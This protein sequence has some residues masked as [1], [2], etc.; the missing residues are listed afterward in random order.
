[1][2][3]VETAPVE[4]PAP[5]ANPRPPEGKIPGLDITWGQADDADWTDEFIG[6]LQSAKAQYKDIHVVPCASRWYV[7]RPL[8]RREYRNLVQTQ[9]ETMTQQ[10]ENAASEGLSPEGV[11][12][13]L[14]MMNEE[15]ISVQATIYPAF[16]KDTI[17]NESA[18]VATTL[19]DSILMIS[20]Y[21]S[22]PTPIKV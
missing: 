15:V 18:G 16:D 7:V 11:R 20:G 14:N 9:A 1:M 19:H 2:S 4:A 6:V 21:Q 22:Q 17:R 12:A 3:D 8:N 13:T 5:E 10:T